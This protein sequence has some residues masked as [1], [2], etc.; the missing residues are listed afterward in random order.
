MLIRTICTA[1]LL[2]I[3]N[4]MQT[5]CG[6]INYGVAT[7]ATTAMALHAANIEHANAANRTTAAQ[8]SRWY[9]ES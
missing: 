1:L 7:I 6:W 9:L 8:A 3:D 4:T 2:K 5:Q